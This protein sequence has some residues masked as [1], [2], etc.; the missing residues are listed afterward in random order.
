MEKSDRKSV[1]DAAKQ[2]PRGNAPIKLW[3]GSFILLLQGFAFSTIGNVL[4]SIAI[5]I[6]VYQK[7]GSTAL[8]GTM[9]SI[10]YFASLFL[11]PFGGVLADRLDKRMLI[12]GADAARGAAMLFLGWFAF[13]GTMAVWQVLAVSVLAA[14][15]NIGFSPAASAA[16]SLLVPQNELMRANSMMSGARSL[17]GLIGNAV[18]GFLVAAFGV[19][20]MIV[21]NGISFL[22]SA[23]TEIFIAIPKT[24]HSAAAPTPCALLREFGEGFRYLK[25]SI[26]VFGMLA[27]L[28]TCAYPFLQLGIQYL[29]YKLTAFLAEIVGAGD[30]GKLI[31]GLGGAFGVVLGMTGTCAILLL[32]SI[33]ASIAAVIP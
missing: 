4:Y 7:T 27:I 13:R 15:C 17:I 25:N 2:T 24:A 33:L 1:A 14:V 8:M 26:G 21:L 10:S 9:S 28:A 19:P 20:L 5:G 18:S 32:I 11:Q 29:L 12:V 3:N 31:N 22:V 6:W 23:L 16:V 30:L